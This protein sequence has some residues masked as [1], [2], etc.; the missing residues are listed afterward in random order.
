MYIT[1]YG[2]LGYAQYGTCFAIKVIYESIT[3]AIILVVLIS[4]FNFCSVLLF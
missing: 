2:I 4:L 1:E 3:V